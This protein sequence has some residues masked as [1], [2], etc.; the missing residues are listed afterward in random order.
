MP[1]SLIHH[2]A[3]WPKEAGFASPLG[4]WFWG[5][6]V[7]IKQWCK[8]VF[9]PTTGQTAHLFTLLSFRVPRS[10]PRGVAGQISR[11]SWNLQYIQSKQIRKLGTWLMP[12]VFCWCS[13]G[14]A[15]LIF[16]QL[17]HYVIRGN[18][19]NRVQKPIAPTWQAQTGR[20][21]TVPASSSPGP[22]T[23]QACFLFTLSSISFEFAKNRW[24]W[25]YRLMIP[26][27]PISQWMTITSVLETPSCCPPWSCTLDSFLYQGLVLHGADKVLTD[28]IFLL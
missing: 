17:A 21:G 4:L 25:W 18:V 13:F 7:S 23:G 14:R 15:S 22:P 1:N 3:V 19:L 20:W 12:L 16:I 26:E 24:N 28:D 6:F 9:S 10:Q 8:F 11:W 5:T 27:H 2:Q